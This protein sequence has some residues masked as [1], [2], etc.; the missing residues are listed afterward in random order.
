MRL[1]DEN[2]CL[3]IIKL[4]VEAGCSTSEVDGDDQ[5]PI[6][7]AVARGLVP[8]VE[9][10][11]SR[12]VP[13]P[14]R[15]LFAAMQ[16]P[17]AKRVEMIRLLISKEANLHVLDADGN[18]LLHVTMRCHDRSVCS[19]IAER[20]LA[21]GC[22]LLARNMRGETPLHI[23][24]RQGQHEV[25]GHLILSKPSLDVLSLLQ[26]PVMKPFILCSVVCNTAG[27][28][29][30]SEVKNE[31]QL[32]ARKITD[33]ADECLE[34]AKTFIGE[35][36]D[37]LTRSSVGARILDIAV[38]GGFFRVVNFLYSQGV[39]LPPAI[40][41][42]ALRSRVSMISFLVS[43]G[44]DVHV[45]EDS[46]DTLLHVTMS[47]LEEMQCRATTQV[48]VEAGCNPFSFNST[49]KQPINIAVSQGFHSVVQY[50]LSLYATTS[51]PLPTDVL[52]TAFQAPY[53]MPWLFLDYKMPYVYTGDPLLCTFL[54]S[55][56]ED[57]CLQSME[58]LCPAS[59]DSVA[60]DAA[61]RIAIT[62]EFTSVVDY[63]SRN[64]TLSSDILF[65]ALRSRPGW[66][67]DD[68]KQIS[69]INSLIRNGA[70][71]H[72]Q[73]RNQGTI[74]HWAVW[75]FPESQCLELTKIIVE[76]GSSVSARD[77]REK[78]PI[79]AAL[80]RGR[81]PSVV[82]YLL[83]RTA[84]LPPDILPRV[85]EIR[86]TSCKQVLRMAS[87]LL[88]HRPDVLRATTFGE[89]AL[90]IVLGSD[91]RRWTRENRLEI[92]DVLV[93][94][95][96]D[97]DARDPK[98]R[99]PL[100]LATRRGHLE[101]ALYLQQHRSAVPNTHPSSGQECATVPCPAMLDRAGSTA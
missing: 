43:K 68:H 27:L 11:L 62:R 71:I 64:T 47:T 28:R 57:R 39:P 1:S 31:V 50:L 99:T 100:E 23:A 81:V 90:H 33:D 37:P 22:S 40:L 46:G 30:H 92:V 35:A 25:A 48:L 56:D 85:L 86:G 19:G 95:G 36:R 17:V 49:D 3:V 87:W 93:R 72:A 32:A 51:A 14:S 9:Y 7:V 70:D 89:T 38:R 83:S 84:P 74:L 82:E 59:H 96:C 16:T 98:G 88:Q 66:K 24:A 2:Q 75:V 78:L 67:Q 5:S 58:T 53:N 55:V 52:V 6:R 80:A 34:L 69:I 63:L 45:R 18:G 73:D 15:V 13:L 91:G 97:T 44:A 41:F 61:L 101:V 12:G 54:T 65:F 94:A 20:L 8:V 77:A 29:L 79:E 4:L 76:A 10:L 26:D 60:L 42:T 21:A